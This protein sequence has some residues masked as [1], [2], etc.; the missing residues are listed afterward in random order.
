MSS[1][2]PGL[3]KRLK[4]GDAVAM[5]EKLE[6]A[7]FDVC[8]TARRVEVFDPSTSRYLGGFYW[9]QGQG[10]RPG[11]WR[12]DVALMETF[13]VRDFHNA[14]NELKRIQRLVPRAWDAWRSYSRNKSGK[15]WL[16]YRSIVAM[17]F[18]RQ[19]P[20]ENTDESA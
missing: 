9:I 11:G 14:V 12:F 20:T 18:L 19:D 16:D 7:G 4:K 15:R 17:L 5:R 10:G 13:S 2:N 8:T 1:N 3:R 6:A